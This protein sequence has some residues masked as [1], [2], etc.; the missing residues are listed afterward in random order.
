MGAVEVEG[1]KELRRSLGQIDKSLQ[2]NLR[3]RFKV[4]GDK[5]AARARDRMPRRTGRAA[6][7]VKSGVSGNKAYVQHGK[8]TVP[9]V[10]WLD[11][12]GVLKPTGARRNT[13]T[14]PRIQGGR[15]LYPAIE[16]MAPQTQK[17]ALEAIEATKRE[18]GL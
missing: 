12:G 5:V 3:G 13:I 4:I 18:L 11:F 9:Y 10:G 6:A 8:A 17:E 2:K 16:Q 14:R 1:L 7:S 15:Y